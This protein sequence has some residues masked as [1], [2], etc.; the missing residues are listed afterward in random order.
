MPDLNEQTQRDASHKAH[1]ELPC[2]PGCTF[3]VSGYCMCDDATR[4]RRLSYFGFAL[5]H[6]ASHVM[7]YDACVITLAVQDIRGR[8]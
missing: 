6:E 1:A 7:R 5:S 8:I 4:Y 3:A 2:E